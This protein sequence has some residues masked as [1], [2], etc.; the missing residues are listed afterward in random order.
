M[1]VVRDYC[2]LSQLCCSEMINNIREINNFHVQNALD[3]LFL[4]L[5]F[6]FEIKLTFKWKQVFDPKVN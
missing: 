1:D 6:A 3:V 2:M 5:A 4:V